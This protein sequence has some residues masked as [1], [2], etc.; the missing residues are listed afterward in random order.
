MSLFLPNDTPTAKVVPVPGAVKVP[1]APT[2]F[3]AQQANRQA[4]LDSL[5]GQQKAYDEAP[6][7]LRQAAVDTIANTRANTARTLAQGRGLTGG[8]RGVAL[9]G[10]V[11]QDR[12]LQEGATNAQYSERIQAALAQAANARTNVLEE[13][14][15]ALQLE[16]NRGPAAQ[17]AAAQAEADWQ[18]AMDNT[19]IFTDADATKARNALY[20]K[21][22]LEQDAIVAQAIREVADRRYNEEVN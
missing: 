18:T 7:A 16:A 3:E 9:M 17:A 11:A 14:G 15:K 2:T 6:A 21:A 22:D 13:Q 4:I 12:G 5:Q 1:K 10:Q 19:T 20:A 8:G